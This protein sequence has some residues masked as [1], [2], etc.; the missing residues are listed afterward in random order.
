MIAI[1]LCYYSNFKTTHGG[2]GN[3]GNFTT[4]LKD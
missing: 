2:T 4:A 3:E 1:N